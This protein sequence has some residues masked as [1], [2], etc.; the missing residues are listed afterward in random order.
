ME[1]TYYGTNLSFKIKPSDVHRPTAKW[2]SE[3]LQSSKWTAFRARLLLK[4]GQL[5]ER[6]KV[7]P[8]FSLHHKTYARLFNELEVDVEFLCKNCHTL[9]HKQDDIPYLWL[10]YLHEVPTKDLEEYLANN[11]NAPKIKTANKRKQQ[12]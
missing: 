12:P 3:Y 1:G 2:Y 6:C 10:I 8:H 11:K 9:A 4:R 7:N 5:C